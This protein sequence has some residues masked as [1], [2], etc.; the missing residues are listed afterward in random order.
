MYHDTPGGLDEISSILGS[1]YIRTFDHYG[2]TVC[3][4]RTYPVSAT[5]GL[6]ASWG[7]AIAELNRVKAELTARETATVY[8]ARVRAYAKLQTLA[9]D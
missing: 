9:S 2:A 5:G 8:E 1:E 3:D 4:Y 6:T 7:A